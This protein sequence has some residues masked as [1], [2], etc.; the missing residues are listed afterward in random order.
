MASHFVKENNRKRKYASRAITYHVEMIHDGRTT[1]LTYRSLSKLIKELELS[2]YKVRKFVKAQ[3]DE[4][5]YLRSNK[6]GILYLIKKPVRDLAARARLCEEDQDTGA[7][8]F[9]EFT[10]LYQIVKRFR[11]SY[12]TVAELRAM[13]PKEVECSKTIYDEFKRKGL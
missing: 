10:S 8:Q 9:Q 12:S 2:D 11:V 1:E 6:T 7:P 5:I 4:S 3:R 13:Q